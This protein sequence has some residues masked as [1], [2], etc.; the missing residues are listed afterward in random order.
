MAPEETRRGP[1][2]Q[3]APLS[4][5]PLPVRASARKRIEH[6]REPYGPRNPSPY[7]VVQLH[8]LCGISYTNACMYAIKNKLNLP[9]GHQPWTPNT[10]NSNSGPNA[11]LVIRWSCAGTGETA[12]E[13][14]GVTLWRRWGGCQYL[15]LCEST[16]SRAAAPTRSPLGLQDRVAL[17]QSHAQQIIKVVLE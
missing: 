3:K 10:R 11:C 17:H 5:S 2:P 4:Q 7:G 12:I 8:R 9:C 1:P 13:P 6:C 16:L 15:T 14:S